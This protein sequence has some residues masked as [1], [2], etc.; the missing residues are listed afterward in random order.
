M[1]AEITKSAY[2]NTRI[3]PEVSA[4]IDKVCKERGINRSQFVT[5]LVAE[6]EANHFKMGGEVM[7]TRMIP[8]EIQDLLEKAGVAVVGILCYNLIG[9]AMERAV[10]GEG[11]PKFTN[12]EIEVVSVLVAVSLSLTGYGI[13]KSLAGSK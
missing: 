9:S 3:T 7:Q 13:V 11:K 1:K 8:L 6:N 10:N 12:T 5:H 4:T 2:L